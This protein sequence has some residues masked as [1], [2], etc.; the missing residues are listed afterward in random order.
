[1]YT[2]Y[3]LIQ[4]LFH[5]FLY[6]DDINVN[7][8]NFQT[9]AAYWSEETISYFHS[10]TIVNTTDEFLLLD[11]EN[12]A[13][14]SSNRVSAKFN[15]SNKFSIDLEKS[16]VLDLF[17]GTGSFGLECLSRKVRHVSFVENYKVILPILPLLIF[18]SS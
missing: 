16:Y 12:L 11:F 17:S 14:N 7:F 13:T 8:S 9:F 15:H 1:M 3:N 2:L 4:Y 5:A 18:L 6:S 10:D